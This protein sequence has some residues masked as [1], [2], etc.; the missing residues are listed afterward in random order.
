[1]TLKERAVKFKEKGRNLDREGQRM[2][3]KKGEDIERPRE[4]VREEEY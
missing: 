2:K 1:M 3:R 4:V